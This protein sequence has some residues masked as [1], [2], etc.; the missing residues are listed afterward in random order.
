MKSH[1]HYKTREGNEA[2]NLNIV[3]KS[4]VEVRNPIGKGGV[5]SFAEGPK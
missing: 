3:G 5:G 1:H 2:K 4:N